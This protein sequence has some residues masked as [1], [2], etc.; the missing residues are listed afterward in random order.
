MNIIILYLSLFS[1][2]ILQIHPQSFA[3]ARLSTL[4]TKEID[5][6]IKQFN[7]IHS[8]Q[9]MFQFIPKWSV[10]QDL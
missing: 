10:L 2:F 8:S 1:S 5:F 7:H 4:Q 3:K 9:E 6:Q